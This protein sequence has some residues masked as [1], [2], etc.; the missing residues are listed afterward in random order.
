[1][2]LARRRTLSKRAGAPPLSCI[3]DA[4]PRVTVLIRII[5][6]PDAREPTM[7]SRAGRQLFSQV[8]MLDAIFGV[9][10]LSPLVEA[11]F[12]DQGERWNVAWSNRSHKVTHVMCL[13]PSALRQT[14]L[15]MRNRDCDGPERL[16]TQAQRRFWHRDASIPDRGDY[17]TV[18]GR[19]SP[20]NFLGQWPV[21][22][23]AG[24]C[25]PLRAGHPRTSTEQT[26]ASHAAVST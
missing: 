1:L 9:Y 21:P 10:V 20:A 15:R 22:T 14:P 17:G 18:C 24:N 16:R 13:E 19:P 26:N 4:S 5:C 25:D 7:L 12:G 3:N 8:D 2:I 23:K 6:Q 11:K